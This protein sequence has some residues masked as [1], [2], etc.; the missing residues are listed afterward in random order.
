MI[1]AQAESKWTS[2]RLEISC[3]DPHWSAAVICIQTGP[4]PKVTKLCVSHVC[5]DQQ[6]TKPLSELAACF[7]IHSGPRSLISKHCDWG[8]DHSEH[9]FATARLLKAPLDTFH[10]V[11][12]RLC[13]LKLETKTWTFTVNFCCCNRLLLF[14]ILEMQM[15]FLSYSSNRFICLKRIHKTPPSRWHIRLCY[16]HLLEAC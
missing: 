3:F 11:S 14:D 8:D 7:Q 9:R 5:V 15:Q 13:N 16:T 6:Y 12:F 4:T 1:E 2:V 10:S